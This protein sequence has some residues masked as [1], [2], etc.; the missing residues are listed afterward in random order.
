MEDQSGFIIVHSYD[1]ISK[2]SVVVHKGIE[3]A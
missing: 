1:V 2:S 3:S